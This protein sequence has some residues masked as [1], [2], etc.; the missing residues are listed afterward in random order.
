VG[1]FIA[2]H[3]LTPDT[4]YYEAEIM[5]TGMDGSISVGLYSKWYSLDVHVGFAF[6]SIGLMMVDG[7]CIAICNVWSLDF[8][9]WKTA[10]EQKPKITCGRQN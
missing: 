3:P 10:S 2:G 9:K 6:E 1:V 4:W 8:E 5:D 7:R